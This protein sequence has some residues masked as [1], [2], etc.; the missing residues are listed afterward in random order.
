ALK[1]S[2][3]KLACY[4][5]T[6]FMSAG[7]HGFNVTLEISFHSSDRIPHLVTVLPTIIGKSPIPLITPILNEQ[8][9]GTKAY[10]ILNRFGDKIGDYLES[11]FPGLNWHLQWFDNSNNEIRPSPV[12]ALY[13][14]RMSLCDK[15]DY[16]DVINNC[17]LST[18]VTKNYK[19]DFD[20]EE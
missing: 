17:C 9:F 2:L 18:V 14:V 16:D 13:R 8:G 3:N 1:T 15:F 7:G 12:D 10:V 5:Q 19:N 11:A 20:Y 4:F 6:C